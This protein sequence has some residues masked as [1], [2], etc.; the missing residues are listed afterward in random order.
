MIARR[1]AVAL[2]ILVCVT[3]LLFSYNSWKQKLAGDSGDVTAVTEP[4][5]GIAATGVEQGDSA[6]E[7]RPTTGEFD[8]LKDS[9]LA[10]LSANTDARMASLLE[11]RFEADEHVKLL[12]VGSQAIEQGGNGGAAGMLADSLALAYKGFIETDILPFAGTSREFVEQMDDLVDVSAYD[13]VLLE[14]FTLNNNGRVVIEDEH[15]HILRL[16]DTLQEDAVLL[17]MPSQP[18]HRPNFYLTQIRSLGNFA[19]V[20]E[21]PYIDHWTAW[22]D[23]ADEAILGYLDEDSG[24]NDVGATA[25]GEALVDYF[26]GGRE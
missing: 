19:A 8:R 13:V 24:P 3:A 26:T 15:R 21:I 17:L 10:A 16:R 7:E 2:F 6:N 12:I 18:I 11:S 9:E 4:L 23:V 22:P 5:A 14:P 25:W 20:R 1:I